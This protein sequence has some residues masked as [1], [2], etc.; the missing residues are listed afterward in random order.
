MYSV[1]KEVGDTELFILKDGETEFGKETFIVNDS[2]E[3][4]RLLKLNNRQ[5]IETNFNAFFVRTGERNILIDAGAG[6]LLVRLL[7]I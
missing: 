6:N 5:A 3:I 1:K 7:V 2:N 4:Q